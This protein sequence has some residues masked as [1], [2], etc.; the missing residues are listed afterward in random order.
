MA[1]VVRLLLFLSLTTAALLAQVADPT[2]AAQA[3]VAGVGHHY[4]GI[5][6]ETVN[7]A[8]GMLSFDLPVQLPP[9][10]QLSFP[11]GI[12]FNGGEAFRIEGKFNGIAWNINPP[13]VPNEYGGW[14]Y[15]LPAYTARDRIQYIYH[16]LAGTFYCYGTDSYVFYGFD[17]TQHNLSQLNSSYGSSSNPN[18][19]RCG[20]GGNA[21]ANDEGTAAL[22]GTVGTI[23]QPPL[24]VTERD[25][26]V[27]QFPQGPAIDG[28]A[29]PSTVVTWGMLAQT[30]TDR[31]G[32]RLTL[33][34]S[35]SCSGS[36][37]GSASRALPSGYYTDT[38]GR[39]VISW[40]GIGS[41][42]G[43]QLT[44]S[45]LA[46]NLIVRWTNVNTTLPGTTYYVSGTA[47]CPLSSSTVSVPSVSE[48]DLPNGQKYTFTYG[49]TW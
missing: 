13:G 28:L 18:S 32:N 20:A 37:T 30:I 3:P 2:T 44:V 14:S 43:D 22:L 34:C 25:G 27:Y 36:T 12:R 45:G 17:K 42:T 9:G 11:F 29:D 15:E 39:R 31:N 7:P 5:G 38:L 1:R 33:N 4:I 24:T 16:D 10:R 46:N 6:A 19:S 48:I 8:S 23:A 21:S 35:S 41:S 47:P 49:G 26:T 40:S